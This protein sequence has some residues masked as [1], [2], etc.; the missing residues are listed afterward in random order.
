MERVG[1][2]LAAGKGKLE[3][4]FGMPVFDLKYQD[5]FT[6]RVS[7]ADGTVLIDAATPFAK[8]HVRAWASFERRCLVLECDASFQGGSRVNVSVEKVLVAT[9]SWLHAQSRQGQHRYDPDR[10]Y[11]CTLSAMVIKSATVVS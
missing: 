2:A 5:D 4:D 6:G 7:I 10:G 11:V 1:N 9:N 3:V 8:V